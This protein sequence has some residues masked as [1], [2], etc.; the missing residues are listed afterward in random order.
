ML[1]LLARLHCEHV[2]VS[3]ELLAAARV[4][5]RHRGREL[6]LRLL[7]RELHPGLDQGRDLRQAQAMRGQRL[8][9]EAREVAGAQGVGVGLDPLQHRPHLRVG[10]AAQH[11]A[12]AHAKAG[13][14]R[15]GQALQVAA[16]AVARGLRVGEEAWHW[17][18]SRAFGFSP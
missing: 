7:R 6:L 3:G 17:R 15:V 5:R 8:G 16:Q 2:D 4:E 9:R 1:E 14:G 18:L 12:Q 10:L 11:Q 13:E